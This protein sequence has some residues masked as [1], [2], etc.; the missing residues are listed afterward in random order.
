LSEKFLDIVLEAVYNNNRKFV[1]T[2][3]HYNKYRGG[4]DLSKTLLEV[5]NLKTSFNTEEGLIKAVNDVSFNI[6]EDTEVQASF[7]IKEFDLDINI[8]GEGTIEPSAGTHSFEYGDEITLTANPDEGWSFQEWS[9]DIS[10]TEDEMTV[11][12]D[13]DKSVTA[14]FE[15]EVEHYELS[16]D[17]IGDGTV[18]VNPDLDEYEE[19]A[20]VTLTAVPSDNFEFLEWSGD[21]TGTDKEI[22]VV[23]DE[24]KEITA[25]FEEEPYLPPDVDDE[26]GLP[27]MWIGIGVIGIA[28]I[29]I[30]FFMRKS[31][32]GL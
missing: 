6:E 13:E 20:S 10:S 2:T 5:K 19:G 8:D 22:T 30:F 18:N 7:E 16:V 25:D 32:S 26:E 1:M 14:V 12:M 17:I 24:D 9:G 3:L 29:G 4:F 23:M 11:T 28:L 21:V 27:W 31:G 15:E